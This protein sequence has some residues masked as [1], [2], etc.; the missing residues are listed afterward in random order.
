MEVI[1]QNVVRKDNT[2]LA[3]TH[4]SQLLHY[5]TGVGG[6]IVPLVLW[7]AT[8]RT[9]EGMDEHGKAV[10]NL[11]LSLLL[12]LVISIPAILAF[13]IG[14]LGLMAVGILGFVLPIVNAVKAANGESPSNFMTIRFL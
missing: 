7:L 14:L 13:G 10:I 9:V 8:R 3:L 5:V 1:N 2:L 4:L 12:Y 11:Q 6:F